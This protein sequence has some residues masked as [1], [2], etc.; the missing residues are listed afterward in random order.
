MNNFVKIYTLKLVNVDENVSILTIEKF[1]C[2]LWLNL[3]H[4]ATPES[5]LMFSHTSFHN[6][7]SVLSEAGSEPSALNVSIS[8][9]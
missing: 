9:R 6:G 2:F 7:Q 4:K 3:I 1:N 5:K 8:K